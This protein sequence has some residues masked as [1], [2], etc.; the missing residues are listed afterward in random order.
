[1]AIMRPGKTYWETLGLTTSQAS[2]MVMANANIEYAPGDLLEGELVVSFTLGGIRYESEGDLLQI[3]EDVFSVASGGEPNEGVNIWQGKVPD[4]VQPAPGDG[5]T[6]V[7]LPITDPN[8]GPEG[9]SGSSEAPGAGGISW[10]SLTADLFQAVIHYTRGGVREVVG[11][12]VFK[13]LDDSGI[14]SLR[15]AW[16]GTN[17]YGSSGSLAVD[18]LKSHNIGHVWTRGEHGQKMN[19]NWED[20]NAYLWTPGQEGVR[21]ERHPY[22]NPEQI[23]I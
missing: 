3:Y 2:V 13:Y 18:T 14:A 21:G 10:K 6:W 20:P 11:Y 12:F 7:E 4:P 19:L 15:R 5:P 17:R 1:M 8:E 22:I 9:E 16:H 23:R